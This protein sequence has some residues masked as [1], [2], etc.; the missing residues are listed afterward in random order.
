MI[1]RRIAVFAGAAAFLAAAP[2]ARRG[3]ELSVAAAA[4]VR[5]AL[6]D[7]R[8][9]FE[10]D[11]GVPVTIS[12]GSSGILA[13][14]IEQGAPFDLFLSAD[15][16]FVS[17][18][19]R[20]GS[21]VPGSRSPYALGTLVIVSAR[22]RPAVAAMRDLSARPFARIAVAN[23][24]SAPYGRAAME[25]LAR[26]NLADALRPR[27]VFAESVRDALRYVE[28]GDADAGFAAESEAR[29]SGLAKYTIPRSLYAPIRQELAIP[30]RSPHRAEAEA[31]SAY[32][33]SA[34]ARETWLRYGYLLP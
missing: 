15:T 19:E 1:S 21:I 27:I 17:G 25:A 9:A 29:G 4:N 16:G 10:K 13:R 24:G 2:A 18:L 14:Q 26:S 11:S 7:I 28:T 6:E 22:G 23:P 34:S 8:T 20:S 31:F 33:R 32:V 5:P 30:A 12:Y 3:T